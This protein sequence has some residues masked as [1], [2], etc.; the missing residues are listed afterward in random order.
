MKIIGIIPA[1]YRSSRFPGKPLADILGKPMIWHVYNQSVK[2]KHL[3]EVYVATDDQRIYDVCVR[4]DMKVVMTS[5]E[6]PTGTD[7]V[8]EAA[9]K[10]HGDLYVN[11]QGDEPLISPDSIDAAITGLEGCT[12]PAVVCLMK[13]IETLTE[14]LNITVPKVVINDAGYAL[15]F[16][17]QAVPYPKGGLEVDYYKQVCVYVFSKDTLAAFRTLSQSRNELIEEIEL[18]RCL[19]N[20]IPV[21]MIEVREESIAVDVPNDLIRVCNM[22]RK[23]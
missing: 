23:Q 11:I 18:L 20:G 22:L 4:Y 14:L 12:G 2:S 13:R 3:D 19:E 17:R 5:G 1:R 7:R 15:F 10:I 8:A 6:H 9:E 16:S 21:K